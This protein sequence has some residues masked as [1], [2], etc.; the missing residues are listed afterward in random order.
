MAATPGP[1]P[2]G[3]RLEPRF[4]LRFQRVGDSGLSHPVG[5]HRDPQGT[6]FA[7]RFRDEHPLDRSGL[8]GRR[9]PVAS[10]RQRRPSRGGQR[11]LPVNAR[12]LAASIVLRHPPN[13]VQRVRLAP[14]HQLLQ[15]TDPLE[16][17]HLRRLE[18]PPPQPSYVFLDLFPAHVFP[19][20]VPAK[21]VVVWSVHRGVQLAHTFRRC[22]RRP[23]KGSPGPRQHPASGP[24]PGRSPRGIRPVIPTLPSE[25]TGA[26]WVGFLLP[27]GHRHSLLGPSCSRHR[28]S[29]SLAVGPPRPTC[30]SDQSGIA[31]FHMRKTRPER[32]PPR[33]RGGGAH[34]A[35][36]MLPAA[37][38]RF[39]TASPAPRSNIH[40]PGAHLDEVSSAV[41][42]RS[43]I[44]SSP[45]LPPP[46]GTRTASASAPRLRTPPLPATHA[47]VGTGC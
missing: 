15:A 9:V 6:L 2:V 36:Q 35:G 12:G 43:P 34:A 27:F 22:H 42:S 41:H 7:V 33:P 14:Q 23:L 32:V 13:T 37:A 45:H 10:H 18:D 3:A 20:Q 16:V 26:C 19:L 5:H 25:E 31:T 4:P 38:C 17:P 44:R 29:A 46:D 39:S 30:I 47:R 28:R 11:D 40:P 1:E 24:A 21:V 8:P